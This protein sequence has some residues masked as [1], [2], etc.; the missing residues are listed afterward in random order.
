[1]I[2][3]YA[4]VST[5]GQT[6]EALTAAGAA[7]LFRETASGAQTDRTQLRRALTALEAHAVV[8]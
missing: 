6:V 8:P 2:Y 4:L 7:K 5:D 3:G 1:M